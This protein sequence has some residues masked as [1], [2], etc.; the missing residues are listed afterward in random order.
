MLRV[1]DR[2][3]TL[4]RLRGTPDVVMIYFLAACLNVAIIVSS[5][6]FTTI[7]FEVGLAGLLLDSCVALPT[8]VVY[9]MTATP[10]L[11]RRLQVLGLLALLFGVITGVSGIILALR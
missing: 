2:P 3:L 10:K 11:H 5:F 7:W 4:P 8:Y 1:P 9:R 6:Y